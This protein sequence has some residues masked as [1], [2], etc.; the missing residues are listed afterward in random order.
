[1]QLDG[2]V[3]VVIDRPATVSRKPV[4]L[5][6]YALPNGN[7]I[8]QTIGKAIQARRRLAF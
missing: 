4:L 5:V 7:T 3:R 2:G 1:M 6:L 8:E